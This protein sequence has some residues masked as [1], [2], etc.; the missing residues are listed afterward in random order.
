MRGFE[1]Q[2]LRVFDAAARAAQEVDRLARKIPLY[3]RALRDQLMRAV[4]SVVL[5]IAEGADEY[6][7][8]EKV[9]F[10]RMARR[11]AAE[12]AAA[13]ELLVRFG[14][15]S[16]SEVA[17]AIELLNQVAAMLSNMMHK[18]EEPDLRT[19]P[20]PQ[21]GPGPGAGPGPQFTKSD[22]P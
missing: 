12:S 9:R 11:S 15:L 22:A 8:R 21:V 20:H 2:R 4:I 10:Y 19:A 17:I 1:F 6:S 7:P 16:R 13:L 18:M 5:N 3:H 14:A